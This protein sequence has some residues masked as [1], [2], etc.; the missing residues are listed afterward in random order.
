MRLAESARVAIEFASLGR[1]TQKHRDPRRPT[2]I[3]EDTKMDRPGTLDG[4]PAD[5][6]RAMSTSAFRRRDGDEP[7][8]WRSSASRSN[9]SLS[10][11]GGRCPNASRQSSPSACE[12]AWLSSLQSWPCF[13][14]LI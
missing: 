2:E 9:A 5:H 11:C 8:T 1:L 7:S 10:S 6:A 12:P 3:L 13:L 4:H 14:S